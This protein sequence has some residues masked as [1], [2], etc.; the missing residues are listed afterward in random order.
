M[1]PSV[2]SICQ[3][4][5]IGFFVLSFLLM[6]ALPVVAAFA[7]GLNLMVSAGQE[8]AHSKKGCCCCKPLNCP[9]DMKK[10]QTRGPMDFDM[11]FSARLGNHA[12]EDAGPLQEPVSQ[13]RPSERARTTHWAFTRAP[14]PIIYLATL[15]L[16]C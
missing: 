5:L 3:S 16:L 15:N 10:D 7:S 8:G 4:V 12:P 1:I 9:C 6:Q 2:R 11:V 14:C 13:S